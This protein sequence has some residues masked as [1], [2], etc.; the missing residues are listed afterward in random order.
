MA[1]K[2]LVC[3]FMAFYDNVCLLWLFL[4]LYCTVV[5]F[6]LSLRKFRGFDDFLTLDL[7]GSIKIPSSESGRAFQKT[8][9]FKL[10]IL[11]QDKN[12]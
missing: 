2:G 6:L 3:Y 11:K 5:F 4:N 1:F 10:T 9:L 7:V 12:T 8:T